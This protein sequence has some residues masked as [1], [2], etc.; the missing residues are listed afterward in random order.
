MKNMMYT[1]YFGERSTEVKGA[2]PLFP[3]DRVQWLLMVT[4][5]KKFY[6]I[7]F[8]TTY[9][10]SLTLRSYSL[11][12]ASAHVASVVVPVLWTTSCIVSV[13][14]TLQQVQGLKTYYVPSAPSASSTLV[15]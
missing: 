15:R 6:K 3:S 12:Q 10:R 4:A 14:M 11:T 1:V 7:V 9:I 8:S 5:E 2:V 13:P